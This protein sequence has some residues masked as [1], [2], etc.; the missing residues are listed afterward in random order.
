M[1]SL[2]CPYMDQPNWMSSGLIGHEYDSAPISIVMSIDD[3][4]FSKPF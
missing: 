4:L 2:F 3:V 1:G